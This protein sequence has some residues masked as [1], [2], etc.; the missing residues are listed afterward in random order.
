MNAKPGDSVRVITKKETTEGIL[1]PAPDLNE[2]DSIIIKLN[3]GYNIGVSKKKIT[4]IEIINKHKPQNQKKK[5]IPVNKN[6]P[7]ISILHTG[8]TIASK[9][10]YHTGG[11]VSR[12]TPEELLGMFPEL[13][14][15]VNIRSRLMKNMWSQD[16]RF[17]HY[18]LIA[19]EIK[20]EI[21]NGSEGVIVSQGTDTLHYTSAALSFILEDLSKPVLIV[22][23]QRSSDRGSSDAY[24]NLINAAYFIATSDFAEVGVCMHENMD[25][26]YCHILQG[27]KCRKLHTSRRDAFQPVNSKAFARIN[28]QKKDIQYIRK[29]YAK[30]SDNKLKLKL[31]DEKIKVAILKQHTNMYAE[32]FL[33]YKNYDGLVIEATGLACLPISKID[34]S[35]Q[36]SENIKKAIES[37]IKKGVIVVNAPQTIF[38]RINMNVYEDQRNAQKIGVLGNLNDMTPETT[39]I[40]LAWLLSNYPKEKVKELLLTNLRGELSE[41]IEPSDFIKEM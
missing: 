4:K 14:D 5:N 24:L 20:K 37:V 15:I 3:N 10:D 23:S 8:G 40:K 2:N 18:N 36:E 21:E 32:Q 28:Y 29:K 11:V 27:T 26:N 22:G 12:F 13:K 6:L 17:S 7:T 16:M 33:F 34:D 25:D 1:I 30:K 9:V 31:I 35:T 39:F 41:R 38:G 19:K